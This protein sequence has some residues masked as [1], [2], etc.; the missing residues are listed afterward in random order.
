MSD[1]AASY[2]AGTIPK[3]LFRLIAGEQLGKGIGREVYV[4]LPIPTLVIKF[5]IAAT[6]FQNVLE[7]ETWDR[8]KDCPR[9]ARWFAP[10]VSISICGSIL[11]QKRVE[12]AR[13]NEYP[14]KVPA[15]VA[16]LKRANW[17]MLNGKLVC[18]DYG[19]T[20]LMEEGMTT[21]MKRASWWGGE[22]DDR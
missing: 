19:R 16:D 9:V 18:I 15:F 20:L 14:D 13:L 17:G 22:G 3:D 6:S 7:W 12:K 2:F 10:I 8:I 11:L 5:E 4:F 1:D 21:R